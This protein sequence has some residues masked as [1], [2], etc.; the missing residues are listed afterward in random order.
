[1]QHLLS[2]QRNEQ[3]SVEDTV[4]HLESPLL[5]SELVSLSV[6]LPTQ[7]AGSQKHKV[8]RIDLC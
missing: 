2:P 1:M 6:R 7:L 4:Q 5:Y 8:Y 3:A